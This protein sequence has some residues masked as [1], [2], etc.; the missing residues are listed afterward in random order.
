MMTVESSVPPLALVARDG[1]SRVDGIGRERH[2]KWTADPEGGCAEEGDEESE[3]EGEEEHE[4]AVVRA[5]ERLRFVVWS[6]WKT[7]GETLARDHFLLRGAAGD[8]IPGPAS[9]AGEAQ[10][11]V[12]KVSAGVAAGTAFLIVP[13]LRDRF[14]SVLV[15]VSLF[16]FRLRSGGDVRCFSGPLEILLGAPLPLSVA[17]GACVSALVGDWI[18][19]VVRGLFF[20]GPKERPPFRPEMEDGEE[21]EDRQRERERQ[22][23][24]RRGRHKG[25]LKAAPSLETFRHER[26]LRRSADEK[27]EARRKERQRAGTVVASLA[28]WRLRIVQ[29]EAWGGAVALVL[30]VCCWSLVGAVLYA[31]GREAPVPVIVLLLWTLLGLAA[32]QLLV[33]PF[34]ASF[35][36]ASVVW[37]SSRRRWF[38]GL[39]KGYPSMCRFRLCTVSRDPCQLELFTRQET[40]S[41][42]S[43]SATE[44]PEGA[45]QDGS[46]LPVCS[47]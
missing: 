5:P 41:D 29:R 43:E 34:F 9:P 4:P 27:R 6:F 18:L 10:M 36:A 16:V 38:D 32:A 14:V 39:L 33:F 15:R 1:A 19:A 25:A 28:S 23:R 21:D 26:A 13:V 20:S 35:L 17:V 31:W 7:L 45:P 47:S 46:H 12:L 2:A 44:N 3:E 22:R 42:A 40:P 24:K 30:S 11:A 8:R 37:I